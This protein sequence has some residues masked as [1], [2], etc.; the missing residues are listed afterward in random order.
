MLS[1]KTTQS[2]NSQSIGQ[3]S[4]RCHDVNIYD[5][6][7]IKDVM[8]VVFI[9]ALRVHCTFRTW[10]A[11]AYMVSYQNANMFTTAVI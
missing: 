11:Y 2:A 4:L 6:L 1:S 10:Q 9:D 3:T 8:N 5:L 7:E